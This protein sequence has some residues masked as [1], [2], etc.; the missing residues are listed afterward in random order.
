[1][2]RRA[3]VPV[4]PASCRRRFRHCLS[5]TAR[6]ALQSVLRVCRRRPAAVF[7]HS[8]VDPVH[9]HLEIVCCDTAGN[10]ILCVESEQPVKAESVDRSRVSERFGLFAGDEN[11]GVNE[12][13]R[14]YAGSVGSLADRHSWYGRREHPVSPTESVGVPDT[15][16]WW[17]L[18]AEVESCLRETPVPQLGD[19][20][21]PSVAEDWLLVPC[22]TTR[23]VSPSSY[24]KSEYSLPAVT[25]FTT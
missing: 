20:C 21:C 17:L 2:K 14:V 8:L 25:L 15:H 13:V 1:M 6:S 5:R 18:S 12:L 24:A 9:V 23:I 7:R 11:R 10:D 19:S 4:G 3:S 22:Q 16:A